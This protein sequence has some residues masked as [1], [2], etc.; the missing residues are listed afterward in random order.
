M[1]LG[2]SSPQQTALLAK[3]GR[4]TMDDIFRRAALRRPDAI[5]LADPPNRASVTGGEARRLTYAQADRL[6]SGIAGRL[7][8]LGLKTDEI[9]GMQ[10]ANTVDA[11]L[12][13]LGILRAGLIATPLPLLWRQ[14]DCVA[15]LGRIGATALIVSGR[16]GSVDHSALAMNV[17]ADVFNI[18]QVGGFGDD[19]PDGLVSFDDLY[20]ASTID[21]PPS[22][23]RLINPAAHVAVITWDVCADGL[24][25]V[26]RSHFEVLAAGAA[27]TLESRL[28][29][30]MVILS[31]LALPS[32]AGLA[33]AVMPWLLVGGTLALHHPFDH[34]AFAQ[35]CKAEQGQVIVV[36]GALALRLADSGVFNRRD[37][38]KTVIAA[39]RA[40]EL[41][42][43][44]AAWGDV[45]IGL[46]DIMVFGETALFAA[47]RGGGGRPAA[48]SV[49]PIMAPRGAP[50]ALHMAEVKRSESGTL[51]VRGPL[52]PKFPLPSEVDREGKPL[53]RVGADGFA[54]TEYPCE[55]DPISRLL[56]I[57]GP[58]P[59]MVGVGGY[60]FGLRS[61][62]DI[63]AQAEPGSTVAA[64]PDALGG[65]RL[66]G[67]AA[68][69]DRVREALATRGVNPLV[70]AAFASSRDEER[71]AEA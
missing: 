50:G 69:R 25:P 8:R 10:M 2:Q 61:L 11:V 47:R 68:D 18:R 67:T 38:A 20:A 56:T 7:C 60:R 15:A 35:Q 36:P 54:N 37:G 30:N 31:S 44:S 71:R 65:R 17:A 57:S 66:A 28:D 6:I 26:A 41:L 23:E 39:W 62:T 59:G 32:F 27:I 64:L 40:P 42:A 21:P 55:V 34:V 33:A 46:V 63:A 52:V 48:L 29:Q 4:S 16:I 19:L 49:G 51:A 5:A 24:V 12:M 43:G 53:L 14:A 70:V 1:I 58:P 3:S 9:V 22:V 45:S 13:L